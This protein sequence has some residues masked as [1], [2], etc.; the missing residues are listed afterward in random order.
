MFGLIIIENCSV[1][2]NTWLTKS[3]YAEQKNNIFMKSCR[4]M[5]FD[6]F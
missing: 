4:Q 6:S 2:L 1:F 5:K 3:V